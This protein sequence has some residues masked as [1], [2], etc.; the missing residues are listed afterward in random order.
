MTHLTEDTTIRRG[1]TLDRI[2]GAVRVVLDIHG[3]MTLEI[4]VL[5]RD[6]TVLDELLEKCRLTEEAALAVRDRYAVDVTRLRVCKPWR[7]VRSHTD[8]DDLRLVASD[9]VEGKRRTVLIGITDLTVRYETELDEGLEAVADTEHKTIPLVQHI[10]GCVL[11]GLVPEEGGDELRRAVRL[12]TTGETT[13][14]EDHLRLGDPLRYLLDGITDVL[15][16]HIAYDD[17]LRIESGVGAGLRRI[18][19]TVVAR[20]DRN[21]DMWLLHLDGRRNPLLFRV[22]RNR[23]ICHTLLAVLV[24]VHIAGK[25]LFE[26]ILIGCLEVSELQGLVVVTDLFIVRGNTEVRHDDVRCLHGRIVIDRVTVRCVVKLQKEAAVLIAEDVLDTQARCEIEADVVTHALLQY[27]LCGTTVGRG[28]DGRE[29]TV[30]YELVYVREQGEEGLLHRKLVTVLRLQP[31][32]RMTGCLILRAHDVLRILCGDGE[33]NERRRNIEF[34]EGT[35]HGVLTTDRGDAEV[36][37]CVKCTEQCL[38]WLSPALRFTTR[39][40]EVLLEGEVGILEAGTGGDQLRCGLNDR[41]VGTLVAVLLRD[42]RVVSIGHDRGII[43]M[44]LFDRDLRCHRL[45]RCALILTAE[46]HQHG[47]GTDGGVETLAEATLADHVEI[48]GQCLIVLGEA[49][50]HLTD[51]AFARRGL[52]GNVLLGT[53]TVQ[54]VSR[55]IND[56]LSVPV[57]DETIGIGDVCYVRRLEVLLMCECEEAL[58]ILRRDNH[59]HTLL[60]LGDRKLCAIETGILLRN[61]IEVDVETIRELTDRDGYTAGTEVVAALDQ[62]TCL[63]ITEE[64]LQLTLLRCITLLNLCAVLLEGLHI[65]RLGGTGG[66]TDTI[67]TGTTAEEDDDITRCRNLTTY[68][69]CRCGCDDGTDLHTLCNIARM[70]DLIDEAG[71]E[72]DLVT[73]AGVTVGCGGHEL[74]LWQLALHGLLYRYSR[75]A[76]TGDTHRLIYIASAGQRITDRATD[77]GCRTT[78]RL[79]LGRVVMGLVLKEQE[80]VLILAIDIDLDLYGAGIDLLRLIELLE[81]AFL[82]QHLRSEGADIHEVDRL[83]AVQLLAGCDVTIPGLLKLR[84]GEIHLIDRGQEGGMTAVIGPV[85]IDHT[86]LRDARITML[87]LEVITAELEIIEVH[88]EA[89]LLTEGIK[90][91]IRCID[92]A[93]EGLNLGRDLILHIEGCIGIEGSLSRLHRVDDILLD[94]CDLVR[95]QITVEEVHLCGTYLR[96]LTLGEDLD[97]LCGRVCAL[98]ELTRQELDGE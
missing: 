47:T 76:G 95:A 27:R 73:I 21:Q 79:D 69:L 83:R 3:R 29:L 32:Y 94:F 56:I 30:E 84:I 22:I 97:A 65:V 28:V 59:G 37:L 8:V 10:H 86:D 13:R 90:L 23:D 96:A 46:R 57:C 68:V 34:L 45:Y 64:T 67:T 33:G 49:A 4:H 35:G 93:G 53:V 15:L 19:L 78:E 63:R 26:L 16:R 24:E 48:L 71:R 31:E 43:G 9:R 18:I 87:G 60:R 39:L 11:H 77:T 12:V 74:T 51:N 75:I 66:T 92:E 89:L 54:E 40:T 80:P 58:H 50:L 25:Y 2:V 70:I 17:D 5:G 42:E 61:L 81:L 72:A 98:V 20:E 52:H 7:H 85:G 55:K 62:L 36:E 14:D 88:R 91:L 6:L 41:E 38:E 82:L 44:T 1:D